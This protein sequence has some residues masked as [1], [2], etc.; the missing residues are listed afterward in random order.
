MGRGS[1]SIKMNGQKKLA[2][3]FRNM[4]LETRRKVK[5]STKKHTYMM[6]REAK[7]KAPYDTG[8]LK[9]S[10]RSSFH[11][12]GLTGIVTVG[13]FYGVYLEFGTRYMRPQPFL[14]PSFLIAK[15]A[16]LRDLESII[17]RID[18]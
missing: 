5:E 7:I 12:D 2:L 13:A 17:R 15:A 1:F 18:S 10:I 6:E 14:F 11:N 16:Y 9:R 4:S 3:K 8:H